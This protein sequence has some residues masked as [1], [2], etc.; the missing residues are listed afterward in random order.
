[1]YMCVF[2]YKCVCHLCGCVCERERESES[3]NTIYY[4]IEQIWFAKH[5]L[6]SAWLGRGEGVDKTIYSPLFNEI[7]E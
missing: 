1:M 4:L 6:V 5:W 7:N 2:I 3:I